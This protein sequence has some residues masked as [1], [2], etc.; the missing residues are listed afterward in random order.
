MTAA[1]LG[2]LMGS[3]NLPLG[4]LIFGQGRTIFLYV[5]LPRTLACLV[6]GAALAVS[7]C[8]TQSVLYNRLATPSIIGVNSGAGLAVTVCTALGIYGWQTSFFS[9]LGAFLTVLIIT[10]GARLWSVSKSTLILL[11]VG[12]NSLFNAIS[13]SIVTLVPDAGVMSNDFKV[14]DFSGVTYE[15]LIPAAVIIVITLGGAFSLTTLIDIISLGD[16]NARGLGLDT[17]KIRPLLLMLAALLAGSAVSVAG[18]LSFVGLIVPHVV[19]IMGA[20]QA[21]HLL[22]LSALFGGGFVTLSDL[23]ARVLF[24]PYEVPVGI[25]MAIIG[26]PFFIFLLFNREGRHDKA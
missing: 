4:E 25:I 3:V 24:A 16:D 10:S 17:G 26:A 1:L 15:T 18:L 2:L 14:G 21:K 20:R 8:I 7:G 12:V 23:L 22:P 11:G 19:R 6:S 5:R 13:S 9:F